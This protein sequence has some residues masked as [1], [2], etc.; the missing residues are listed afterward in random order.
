VVVATGVA[1][2]AT[3]RAADSQDP[4]ATPP[5]SSDTASNAAPA[6]AQPSSDTASESQPQAQVA[7]A[8]PTPQP[9]PDAAPATTNTAPAG[10]GNGNGSGQGNANG[11]GNGNGNGP[12]DKNPAANGNGN[13]NGHANADANS[14]QTQPGNT[15]VT[16]RVDQA[17]D[18]GGVSQNN[19]AQAD[20]T[21]GASNN[22][23]PAQA[24][25]SANASQASPSNV[26]VSARVNSPGDDGAVQ[27][28]NAASANAGAGAAGAV[29]SQAAA[30]AQANQS[31][32]LNVNVSVRVGSSGDQGAISQTNA[33]DATAAGIDPNST[34]LPSQLPTNP[35]GT[36][37]TAT[38]DNSAG[39]GQELDQCGNG[40]A[41]S[42]AGSAGAGAIA[43]PVTT[44]TSAD[45]SQVSP[46]N[47][48]VSV[49]VNS[50]GDNHGLSQANSATADASDAKAAKTGDK[51]INVSVDIS[52]TGP[53]T[54]PNSG[55]PWTWT[56]NWSLGAPIP[57]TAQTDGNA[58]NWNWPS[59]MAPATDPQTAITPVAGHWIWRWTWTNGDQSAGFISDQPCSCTWVWDWVW[60]GSPA[61]TSES[62]APVTTQEAT[63]PTVTQTN[64][65]VASASANATTTIAQTGA[66]TTDAANTG[67]QVSDQSV[68]SSQDVSAVAVVVQ[69]GADNAS[70]VSSD[71]VVTVGQTNAIASVAVAKA[72]F[73]AIQAVL[74]SQS[75]AGDG[76]LHRQGAVQE[77]DN[78][79]TAFASARAAQSQSRNHSEI[80]SKKTSV[81]KIL[82]VV[83]L[84][85]AQAA[86]LATSMS[87]IL[88]N[89]TQT[90]VGG[91]KNQTQ[92]ADQWAVNI[93]VAEASS[94]VA[95]S[96]VGN[97]VDIDFP[98]GGLTNKSAIWNKP[99]IQSNTVGVASEM[100]NTSSIEQAITQM[101]SGPVTWIESA[102]Q[103]AKVIQ[104]GTASALATQTGRFNVVRLT[105]PVAG[106]PTT[107]TGP[108]LEPLQTLAAT[109]AFAPGQ[110]A[111]R[112]IE[113]SVRPRGG[114]ATGPGGLPRHPNRLVSTK[115]SRGGHGASSD[116]TRFVAGSTGAPTPSAAPAQSTPRAT[117]PHAPAPLI[118]L[119]ALCR[120]GLQLGG[121]TRSPSTGAFAALTRP[122]KLAAPGVGRLLDYAPTLG[123]SVDIAAFERPG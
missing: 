62:S 74:Q 8:D 40:C 18:N 84:N 83:Q 65:A 73:T 94:E 57:P 33:A 114:A 12:V 37:N 10:N 21:A 56:W 88:Q 77:I 99:L 19:A 28:S 91:G 24:D 23:G 49:R 39:I 122:F 69:T 105:R 81:T 85:F 13:A 70:F 5:T 9:Q 98:A 3:A 107:Q 34:V 71:F 87:W 67:S 80:S 60:T 35:A 43:A 30:N 53:V 110:S 115:P 75:A 63:T 95:Q 44:D 55:Q 111:D 14:T 54:A 51:N 48:N 118:C 78:L 59:P 123:R 117:T 82:A 93:Q 97:I 45:V 22:A 16:A 113:D 27:Q 26:N 20:A 72:G 106:A 42:A 29:G 47:L 32:P 101:A 6:A 109:R 25:A 112:A 68:I 92:T 61:Q 104:T 2:T 86:A 52:G 31:S 36:N 17:G 46:T 121:L 100:H 4:P 90:Q 66:S 41:S 103:S 38:V 116:R 7:S 102:E 1:G 64:S 76:A 15:S 50:T 108:A 11:Q 58:W 89:L 96:F 120:D 79:Q 119:R